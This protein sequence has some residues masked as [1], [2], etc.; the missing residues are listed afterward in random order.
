L[1]V[2]FEALWIT[3]CNRE[4]DKNIKRQKVMILEAGK[5]VKI[6]RR[7][8]GCQLTLISR[9]AQELEAPLALSRRTTV[10]LNAYYLSHQ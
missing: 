10:S 7:R 8:Y 1:S 2:A 9:L 6:N 4:K 5:G 3:V